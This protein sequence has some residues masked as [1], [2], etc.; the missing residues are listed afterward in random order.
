M[1]HHLLLIERGWACLWTPSPRPRC[2][3]AARGGEGGGGEP[4]GMPG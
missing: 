3:N 4:F 2:P 1:W